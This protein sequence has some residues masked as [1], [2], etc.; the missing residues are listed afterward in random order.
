M[1]AD[2]SVMRATIKRTL[3]HGAGFLLLFVHG[4]YD[5]PEDVRQNSGLFRVLTLHSVSDPL[6]L[7]RTLRHVADICELIT[8]KEAEA[9]IAGKTVRHTS[10]KIPYLI[11]FDDGFRCHGRS[12]GDVLD[13]LGIKAV[14]FICPGIMDLPPWEQKSAVARMMFDPPIPE[15]SIADEQLPL[16]WQ[17]AAELVAAGH[18]IGSHTCFHKRLYQ[19]DEATVLHELTESASMIKRKLAVE[20]DWFAFPY[21]DLMSIDDRSFRLASRRYRYCC[22]NIPSVNLPESARHIIFRT[23]VNLQSPLIYQRLVLAGGVDFR[24]ANSARALLDI[25]RRSERTDCALT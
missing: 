25:V 1:A 17:E 8:P 13:R 7:E 12:I 4:L 19:V 14:F 5:N 24:S 10:G 3:Q 15:A 22:S 2:R 9:L 21:G 18:T 20:V 23:G 11:T 6:A 16:S